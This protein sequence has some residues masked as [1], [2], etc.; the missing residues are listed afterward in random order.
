[1]VLPGKYIH[2]MEAQIH[3]I[4]VMDPRETYAPL[5]LHILPDLDRFES[6]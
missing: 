6:L 2:G 1:M 5:F 4:L 3:H